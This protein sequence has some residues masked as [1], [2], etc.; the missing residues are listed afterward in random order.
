MAVMGLI[1]LGQTPRPDHV[2]NFRRF[3]PGAEIR[4]IGALD[5]LPS[6]EINALSIP[7]DYPLLVKLAD[8]SEK[9]IPLSLLLPYVEQKAQNLADSG[10]DFIVILCAGGFPEISCSVPVLLPGKLVPA[11]VTAISTTKNIGIVSPVKEQVSAA[12]LKWEEDGFT[13][14]ITWASP[15]NHDEVTRAAKEMSDPG[16]ELVVLDCMGHDDEHRKEFAELCKK[17]VILTQTLVARVAG[18]MSDSFSS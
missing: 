2:E 16:I 4:I 11:F 17:P 18:E 14:R 10:A 3:I 12:K 5:N 13:V 7:G 9:N 15:Y 1:T 8:G 6:E